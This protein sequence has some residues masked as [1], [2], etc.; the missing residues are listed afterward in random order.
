MKKRPLIFLL[1]AAVLL[2]I[3]Y[4]ISVNAQWD[5]DEE[6]Q[7]LEEEQMEEAEQGGASEYEGT[8]VKR[9]AEETEGERELEAFKN[10]PT[11]YMSCI[12]VMREINLAGKW[13][14][15]EI[16]PQSGWKYVDEGQYK[17]AISSGIVDAKLKTT[18]YKPY[19]D[20]MQELCKV[21][22]KASGTVHVRSSQKSPEWQIGQN[23]DPPYTQYRELTFQCLAKGERE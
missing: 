10:I 13:D 14:E 18:I 22:V 20:K 9:P 1:L 6:P 8:E 12:Y 16:L 23:Q 4:A 3:A 11:G 2:V 5:T 21:G 19:Y 15:A 7:R 17:R